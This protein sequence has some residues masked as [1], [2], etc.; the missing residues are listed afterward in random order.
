MDAG[1]LTQSVW[2]ITEDE[3]PDGS[4]LGEQ[5]KFLLRYAILAPSSHSSQPWR[6]EIRDEAIERGF[7]EFFDGRVRTC[8][9]HVLS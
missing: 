9:D 8:R 1:E 4:P 5:A 6:F 3:F 7:R 2:D